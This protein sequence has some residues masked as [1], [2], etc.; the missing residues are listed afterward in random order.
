MNNLK[1]RLAKEK[2]FKAYGIISIITALTLL[3]ILFVSI[4]SQGYTAFQETRIQLPVYFD[5]EIL[6]PNKTSDWS[7][8]KKAN[9]NG[10]VKQSI[11]NLFPEVSGRSNKRKLYKIVSSSAEYQIRSIVNNDLSII[12]SKQNI[13]VLADDDV[14]MLIKGNINRNLPENERRIDDQELIWIEYLES[15]NLIKKVFNKTLFT[16][17][18][19][20]ESEQS[21]I[22][23]ALLGSFYALLITLVLS[24][25]IGI[26]TA[27]YLEEFAP[28]DNKFVDFIEV[29]INNLAAVPSII[30]GLLGLAIFLNFFEMPRSA[31]LVGGMVLSL[32]T[33]PRIIIPARAALKSVPPSIREGALGLGASNVQA[34]FHHVLPIAT[35][36]MLTGTIIGMAQALGESAPLLVIGMVAFIVDIPQGFTDPATALPVQIYLWADTPER[37][38]VERTAAVI[39]VLLIFLVLMNSLAIY[40]RKKFE[41]NIT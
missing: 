21:G 14:D 11:R 10:L 26:A 9:F 27:V 19:S 41:K 33:L 7:D 40:L 13:W 1:S 35:P 5:Q 3:T 16:S 24:F 4:F 28:K 36:G 8:I 12:G 2:R 38:F 22:L 6:D 30:F 37:G 17:G 20:S 23:V 18:D 32:M 34:V 15:E 29:N 25:P 39:M 31:P